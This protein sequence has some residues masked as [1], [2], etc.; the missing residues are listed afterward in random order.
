MPICGAVG[1]SNRRGVNKDVSF[2]KTPKIITNQGDEAQILSEQRRRLWK[3][4]VN[5]NDITTEEQWDR[6]LVC[7]RHFVNGEKAYLHSNTS[8]SWVPSLNLEP[9]LNPGAARSIFIDRF[10]EQD[11]GTQQPQLPGNAPVSD[12]SCGCHRSSSSTK[13]RRANCAA[14]SKRR[15]MSPDLEQAAARC[16]EYLGLHEIDNPSIFEDEARLGES[17][18]AMLPPDFHCK[19]CRHAIAV[20]DASMQTDIDLIIEAVPKD[21]THSQKLEDI[22]DPV[23]KTDAAQDRRKCCDRHVKMC[24]RRTGEYKEE[25]RVPKKEEEP[26]QLPDAVFNLQPR[27]VLRRA[28]VSD[29]LHPEW[30]RSVSRHVKEEEVEEVQCIKEEEEEVLHMK[31]EE[32]K[33]II[34]VP[35]TDVHLKSEDEGQSEERQGAEPSESALLAKCVKTH[36][37]FSSSSRCYP[38]TTFRTTRNSSSEGA[39]CGG[40]QTDDDEQSK[41]DMTCHLTNKCWKCSQCGE[42]FASMRNLKQHVKIHTGEKPFACTVCGQRFMW[43]GDLKSHTRTHTGEKPFSCLVCDKRFTWKGDFNRHTRTH[44]GE[45]PFSC[46]VCGKRFMW[47]GD[48][49]RHTRTH[50]GEKPFSCS[51]CGQRFNRNGSLKLHTRTHT[52]EKPFSC[53]FCDKRFTEKGHLTIHT[54]TH[55]GEKPFSCPICDKRFTEK[56]RL[57]KH[58]RTHTG[59]KPFSCPIRD[60]SFPKKGHLKRHTRT[61]TG[62]KLLPAYFGQTLFS[63]TVIP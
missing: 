62:E 55:T 59:E 25:V 47:K 52:G 33:K 20:K 56:G 27:I 63:S 45:K 58:T 34:H 51:V 50:T 28:D 29:Y 61:L 13:R 37:E 46:L 19:C 12:A 17:S 2:Y 15:E 16:T 8:P 53:S 9:M 41:C 54:R 31:E 43:K 38:G 14:Q 32:Q 3:K 26:C 18:S 22:T 60:K 24:A 44:T 4:V 39:H 10:A 1:C 57:K 49:K 36:K 48:L 5:R 35:A 21:H 6:T 40:S 42:T 11:K 7:S 30:Q 23:S